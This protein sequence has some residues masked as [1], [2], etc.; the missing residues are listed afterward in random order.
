MFFFKMGKFFTVFALR[1]HGN[2]IIFQ[3]KPYFFYFY[4]VKTCPS[5]VHVDDDVDGFVEKLKYYF[6]F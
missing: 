6:S 5:C 4:R 2:S 1:S 3:A